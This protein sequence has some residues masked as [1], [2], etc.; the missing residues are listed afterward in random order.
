MT[1]NNVILVDVDPMAEQHPAVARGIWLAQIYDATLELF[2]CDYDPYLE[3]EKAREEFLAQRRQQLLAIAREAEAAGVA[4]ATEVV[5]DHPID[6]A[7]LRKT[8][9]VKPRFL[10]K[11][12][13]FHPV[14]K[15]T[16]FSNTDWSLIRNCPADLLLVKP[17]ELGQPVK[18]LAAV[19]PLHDHDKPADLDRRILSVAKELASRA[20]GELSMFHAFDPTPAIAAASTTIATPI[21]IPI[22]EVTTAVEQRHKEALGKLAD[23]VGVPPEKIH[24]HQGLPKDLLPAITEQQHTDIVVMGAVSR[25]GIKRI[26]I[27]HTAERVLDRLP[28]DLLVI[29]PANFESRT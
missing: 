20:D 5:W 16:I 7:L 9:T 4:V 12:T 26:F 13:H 14:L 29:K 24:M 3:R 19:D 10:V 22:A 6:D 18:I 11:D 17:T 23:Q 21:A 27:G 25:R 1:T 2:I 8:A 28:C 15:R